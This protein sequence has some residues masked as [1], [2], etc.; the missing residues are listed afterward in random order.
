[1]KNKPAVIAVV[2]PTATGKTRLGIELAKYYNG[3]IISCDSMQ[4][5]RGLPI[6]TAQP[7]ADELAAVPHHLIAFADPREAFSVSDYVA[8]ASGKIDELWGRGKMPVL[9]GGTGLYARSLLRGFCF[10]DGCRDEALRKQLTEEAGKIGQQAIYDKLKMLDPKAAAEIHPNN[11]PRIIRAV[12]YC[13]LEG[14][15]FSAKAEESKALESP[16]RYHMLCLTYKDR[17]KLYDRIDTRVDRMLQAGLLQE[18]ESFY[19]CC[20]QAGRPLTASQAIGYKELFPYLDDIVS[21]EEAVDCLKRESRRY[22]KR[23]ITWF[24]KEENISFLYLD[25]IEN[26]RDLLNKSI[27]ILTG[28]GIDAKEENTK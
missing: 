12:E 20:R 28:N 8:L 6:G 19:N 17:Q 4:I 13:I 27:E 23:Q 11:L 22:A 5:Y 2:G 3:E 1:M 16:Y 18:A 25:E 9:V 26:N 7:S 24:K 10:E 14:K 15:P 21:L